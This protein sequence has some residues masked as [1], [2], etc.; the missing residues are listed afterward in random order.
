MKCNKCL[1]TIPLGE[2]ILKSNGG[3]SRFLCIKCYE[4]EKLNLQSFFIFMGVVIVMII[5]ILGIIY[6]YGN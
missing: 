1:I 3:I 4:E 5:V 6:K 2:E